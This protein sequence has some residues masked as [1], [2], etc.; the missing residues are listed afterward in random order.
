MILQR[1]IVALPAAIA[2]SLASATPAR[3][4]A[5]P[6]SLASSRSAARNYEIG[7]LALNAIDT[8]QTLDC[9]HRDRCEEANPLFGRHP[10]PL[11]LI[12]MKAAFSV[13]HF[14]IFEHINRRNPRGAR[15]FAQGSLLVQGGV[16]LLNARMLFK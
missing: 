7:Y 14:A 5:D 6:L 2:L 8:G 12:A 3:A 1:F 9:L 13:V 11:R 10:E 15:L 4:E 16:V